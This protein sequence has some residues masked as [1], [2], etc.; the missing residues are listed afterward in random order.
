ML[1]PGSVAPLFQLPDQDGQTV[2]LT[3]L[4]GRWVVLYFYPK[5]D[6]PGCTIE[7]CEFTAARSAFDGLDAIVLGCSADAVVSHRRFIDKHRLGVRL[8][9]DADHSVMKA[10]GAWG[11]KTLYGR[12]FLG[13]LRSTVII[14]PDGTLAHHWATVKAQGHAQQVRS[15]LAELQGIGTGEAIL[16][17]AAKPSPE[18]LAARKPAA[19]RAPSLARSSKRASGAVAVKAPGKAAAKSG[20]ARTDRPAGKL[21]AKTKSK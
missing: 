2:A 8:L 21:R 13:V 16:T 19:T 20:S 18:K 3:D 11:K 5:D 14:A 10:Y 7:A 6:T 17:P 15:K 1:E 9:T 12:E 4:R